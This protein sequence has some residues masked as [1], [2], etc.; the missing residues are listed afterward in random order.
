MIGEQK[1]QMAIEH[2]RMMSKY[3]RQQRSASELKF[4]KKEK[5]TVGS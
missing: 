2:V 3:N 1:K 4:R 5:L